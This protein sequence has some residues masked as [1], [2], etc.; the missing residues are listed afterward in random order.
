MKETFDDYFKRHNGKIVKV[1]GLAYRI[2]YSEHR[3]KYPYAHLSTMIS[4]DPV[5][6]RSEHY[7]KI[8]RKLGDD[9]STD[10][11]N[12]SE[13]TMRQIAAQLGVPK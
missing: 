6:K 2:K 8:K 5:N 4:L 1:D 13:S 11:K 10:L 7:L 9:W 3:A 12:A